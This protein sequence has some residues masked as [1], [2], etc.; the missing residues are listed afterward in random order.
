ASFK[1]IAQSPRFS[2]D[3]RSL[4]VLATFAARKE[5]GATQAGVRQVGEIGEENDEQRIAVVPLTGGTFRPIS[6]DN[7]YVYEYDWLPDASGFVVTS[8][9]GNGDNNW[10]VA[11]IDRIDVATGAVARIATPKMQ[12]NFPRVSP[13]GRT[14][15]FIGGLMSDF[16]PVGGDVY[17]VPVGGGTPTDVHANFKGTFTSLLWDQNGLAGTALIGDRMAIL[18]IDP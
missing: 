3:G 9:L 1:G 2:P 17:T 6:P 4:A 5:S 8:A 7:R 14:V 11:T 15:A 13:D 12:V 16:G 10:W 18:P